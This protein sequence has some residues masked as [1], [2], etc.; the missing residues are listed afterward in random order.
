MMSNLEFQGHHLTDWAISVQLTISIVDRD[1]A[2]EAGCVDAMFTDILDINAQSLTAA[3]ASAECSA[4]VSR[5]PMVALK[6]SF[7]PWVPRTKAQGFFNSLI[8]KIASSSPNWLISQ[9][10]S[11]LTSLKRLECDQI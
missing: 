5:V 4:W 1:G 10:V 11:S 7:D 6:L 3:I 9:M 2:G 8:A